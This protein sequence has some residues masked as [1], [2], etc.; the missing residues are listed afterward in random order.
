MTTYIGFSLKNCP[1]QALKPLSLV[2]DYDDLG[3][4]CKYRPITWTFAH[5]PFNLM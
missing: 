3:S 4:T 1:R 2:N 5:H